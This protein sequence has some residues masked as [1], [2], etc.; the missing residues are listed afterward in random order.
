MNALGQRCSPVTFEATSHPLRHSASGAWINTT[1]PPP[2][3][4]ARNTL[5]SSPCSIR[6]RHWRGTPRE[7]QDA[8]ATGEE[9]AEARQGMSTSSTVFDRVP[10][11]AGQYHASDVFIEDTMPD[12]QLTSGRS[13]RM[14]MYKTQ[15]S[16]GV[17]L[18]CPALLRTMRSTVG[19]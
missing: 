19:L 6:G 2:Y 7:G 10:Y 17:P 12:K 14:A 15:R 11:L 8:A 4:R 13:I 5:A 18:A 9:L 16:R 3:R 1:T